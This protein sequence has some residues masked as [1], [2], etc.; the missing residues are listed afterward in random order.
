ML[1]GFAEI[2]PYL[3]HPLVLAGFALFLLFGLLRVL[4]AS[5][6]MPT[7]SQRTGGKALLRAI[8]FGFVAALLV[9]IVL[10]FALAFYQTTRTTVDVDAILEDFRAATEAAAAS[11]GKLDAIAHLDEIEDSDAFRAAVTAIVRESKSPDAPRGI[12][13]AIAL[14][15]QG[16][17]G[18]AETVLTEILDRRLQE[19]ATASAEAAEAAR[20]LGAIASFS[21]TAKALEAYR[22][23]TDLDPA[24]TWSWIH[25]GR[26]YQQAGDLAAAEQ[27]FKQARAAAERAGNERDI[28]AAGDGL[29]DAQLA[30]GNLE[31]ALQAYQDGLEIARQLEQQAPRNAAVQRDLSV[32]FSRIGNVQLA[33]G[34]LD[35][36]LQAYQHS[37]AIL[38]ELAAQNPGN[39][40]RQRDLWVA[41]NRIS[42][43]QRA[44]GNLDGALRAYQRS[45]A[46]FEELA[47]QNP[48]NAQRQRDLS[49]SFNRIGNVQL[50]RGDLDGA[51]QAYQHGHAIFDELAGQDRGNAGAQ[52]DL[53]DSFSRI[54][55]VQRARGNLDGALQAYQHSHAIL[56]NLA[57]LDQSNAH[58]QRDLSVS[59]EKIGDVQ[60]A[61]GDLDGAFQAYQDDLAIA[62]ELAVQDQSNAGWQRDLSVSFEKIGDVQA[63]RGDLDGALEAHLDSLAIREKLA[64]QDQGNAE[65]QRDLIVSN[66]KLAQIAGADGERVADARK[67]YRAALAIA[68]RLAEENRLAPVDAWMVEDLEARIERLE[69]ATAADIGDP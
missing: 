6:V 21:D 20:H 13:Q 29:G 51:L 57:A 45:H 14:L 66:V 49:V 12:D 54:G 31:G 39:A 32:S 34:D 52:R 69:A 61:R 2:A 47:A 55:N 63:A 50:A 68:E 22:I 65:W 67:H 41:L 5:K 24:D 23:A 26:L 64:A 10:G 35:G 15:R 27:A 59:F 43:V 62:K 56:E 16:K 37:H 8:H 4:L 60:A 42:D 30:R 28:A 46:I 40:Q 38:V 48:G 7:V 11:E 19:R 53:S 18:A 44:R 58:W 25:L 1:S 17:T 36:A 33:R 3:T 9:V